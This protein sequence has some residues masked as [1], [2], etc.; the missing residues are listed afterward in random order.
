MVAVPLLALHVA[1]VI[2]MV[3]VMTGGCV[4]LKVCVIV[5]PAGPEVI[6]QVYVPAHNPLAVEPVPPE[7]AHA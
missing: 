3:E 4:M 6:V 2:L 5:H 7:G 1:C